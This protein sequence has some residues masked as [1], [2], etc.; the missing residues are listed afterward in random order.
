MDREVEV[1]ETYR[2]IEAVRRAP[3][4]AGLSIP[5]IAKKIVMAIIENIWEH[6]SD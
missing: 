3:R 1:V 2:N 4:E 6:R 5:S